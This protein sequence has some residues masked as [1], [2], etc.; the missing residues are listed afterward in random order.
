MP[1]PTQINLDDLDRGT[2]ALPEVLKMMGYSSLRK[3]QEEPVT[4]LMMGQDVLAILPTGGGKTAIY[5][6]VTKALEHKTIVFSPLVALM[7]DQVQ[8]LN[9]KGVR[10]AAVNSAQP[11]VLN[12][13][14]L[15]SW[16]AGKLDV[17][18]VA[19]ERM[20]NPQFCAAVDMCPPSMVAGD[21]IHCASTWST[22]FRPS[23]ARLGDFVAKYNPK[24]VL[25]I[26]ATA[27]K[28]IVADVKR[29]LGIENCAMCKYLPPRTNIELH[30]KFVQE[31]NL[32]HEVLRKV[33]SI[34]GPIIVYCST[35]QDVK[36]MTKFLADMGEEVTFYH[37]QIT[38]VSDK[39][40]NQDEF[41][42]GRKRIMVAT[43]A[44]GMGIDKADIRGIIHMSPPGSVE[45]ISQ[46][47]GRAA[48]DGKKAESWMFNTPRGM[49]MQNYL[50]KTGN[51][52]AKEVE[53][54]FGFLH[55]RQDSK[56]DVRMTVEDI[57]KAVKIDAT[58]GALNMLTN[59]G[60]ITRYTPDTDIRQFF[61]NDDNMESLDNATQKLIIQGIR[62]GGLRKG[63]TAEGWSIWE[64]D[65]AMV[66][67]ASG[68]TAPTVQ[69]HLRQLEKNNFLQA[70]PT[71]KGK[72]THIERPPTEEE[73]EMAAM[74]YI[75]E[76]KKL[77]DVVTYCDLPDDKKQDYLTHY[78]DLDGE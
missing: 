67:R 53:K 78:F 70:V 76:K 8:S 3:G 9:K 40:I 71:F 18:L 52:R 56:G 20:E 51:P 27:T 50:F 48:R 39:A 1:R 55:D 14:A 57:K 23:Y 7:Q 75:A 72:V 73:L 10:A 26:T 13:S 41:M 62:E 47:V 45:A 2:A 31:E 68:R 44:F 12:T 32:Y 5:A 21:E 35:V 22:V 49:Q 43:N 74:R 54:V 16:A 36:S 60:C 58:Q 37:G 63:L 59:F 66:V 28:E 11:E 42:S 46:E 69:S 30:S 33:R 17:L 65:Y 25:A 38:S 4:R 61:L 15:Q 24:V 34:Q 64:V 19:P 6:A 77:D 29:I